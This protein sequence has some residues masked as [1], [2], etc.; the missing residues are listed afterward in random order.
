ML[1]ELLLETALDAVLDVAT[2][3]IS[4]KVTDVAVDFVSEVFDI[5]ED[6]TKEALDIIG[7]VVSELPILDF[8]V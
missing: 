6:D 3:E 2:Y 7:S 5:S 8:F 4:K 1:G